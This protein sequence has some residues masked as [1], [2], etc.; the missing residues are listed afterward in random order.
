MTSHGDSV[1]A[2]GGR[3]VPPVPGWRRNA[4]FFPPRSPDFRYSDRLYLYRSRHCVGTPIR[5]VPARV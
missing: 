1:R 4:I 5:T 2:S 3:G